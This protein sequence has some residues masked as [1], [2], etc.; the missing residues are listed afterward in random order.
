MT[1]V[2]TCALPISAF[3]QIDGVCIDAGQ[4]ANN[5]STEPLYRF[6]GDR[7]ERAYLI[8]A[9]ERIRGWLEERDFRLRF[10]EWSCGPDAAAC[11]AQSDA[12]ACGQLGCFWAPAVRVGITEAD[13]CL[14]WEPAPMAL[15]LA[16]NPYY[17]INESGNSFEGSSVRRF[18]YETEA[19]FHV[20]ELTVSDYARFHSAGQIG[21]GS[22]WG[23]CH[24]YTGAQVCACGD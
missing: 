1:G 23:D 15:C 17:L 6:V 8:D 13:R 11:E 12:E 22:S 20:V 18:Y 16:P 2:Q 24:P 5:G 21:P 4:C 7:T 9:W 10:P 14:G 3:G 19:G